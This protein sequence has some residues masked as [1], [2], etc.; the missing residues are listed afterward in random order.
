MNE[1]TTAKKTWVDKFLDGVERVCNKLPPPAILFFWL[2]FLVGIIGAIFTMAGVT[3]VNPASGEAVASANL[4]STEGLHWFLDNMVKNFTGFAPLG[5][6]ISMTLG[7]GLCEESG[8]ILSMLRSSLKNVPPTL[9]PYIVAFVG[10]VGNI[11]SDTSCVVIPPL[12]A[13]IYMGVG[14]HPVVGMIAG[15]AGAQAGFS[16]NLMIAGTDSLLQGLTNDAIKGFLPDSTFQ[17]DVTCNWF[18]MI[19]STFLCAAVIGFVCEHIVGPRFSKFS[20]GSAEKM[21]EVTPEQRKGL[22][23]AGITAI[24][25]IL[26]L[27]AGFFGFGRPL[28]GENGAFVGSPFLKGLI[29]ILFILFSICGLAYGYASGTF[30]NTTDVNKAMAKQMAGMG[31]YVLFCFFCGQFQALFNWTK[32]GTMLA[33]AGADFLENVGFTGLPMCVVFILISAFVN[34]FV[35][36]GSAKWAIFAP[37]FVPMF[38]LLGYHPGFTQLCY[39][40]GDS[41]GNAF[42]PMSPYIWMTLSVAQT[43]YDPNIKIGTLISNMIPVA[44]ILQVIWII[45]LI[46]WAVAGLP[47]GPGVGMTL[48][49]G[50]L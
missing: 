14:K 33:I 3:L 10:T 40:L 20:G 19:A 44:V 7:V 2:F 17:V 8:L 34:I 5:L 21:E 41:P 16:A 28:A 9:V 6:V 43:K 1:N 39:R 36:S 25:Y 23:A 45:F 47:I 4:F 35:S 46:I 27:L 26:I 18:F 31:S 32:L 49:A 29:P 15:Y 38:M 37:I 11:A 30:K 42:T 13:I 24:V 50:I 48:P 22:R 12:A